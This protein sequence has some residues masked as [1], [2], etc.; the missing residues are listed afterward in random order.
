MIAPDSLYEVVGDQMVEKP[1][2][3]AYETGLA[4]LLIRLMGPHVWANRLGELY[5]EMLFSLRPAVARDRRPDVAFVSAQRWPVGRLAPRGESWALV[6][7]LAIEVISPS[8]SAT[9]MLAK[10]REYLKAG[11]A[12]RLGGLSR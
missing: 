7:D 6:P 10:V 1:P 2:M 11:G 8:N 12:G 5:M 9:G 3:G 4:N